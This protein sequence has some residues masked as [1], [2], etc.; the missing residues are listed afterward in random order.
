[1]T[2]TIA[3][4]PTDEFERRLGKLS[5]ETGIPKGQIIRE[6]IEEIG[7]AN[8][9]V[10]GAVVRPDTLLEEDVSASTIHEELVNGLFVPGRTNMANI[11]HFRCELVTN[12]KTWAD[13]QGKLLSIVN[14]P[15]SGRRVAP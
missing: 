6:Q 12:P 11:A 4:R 9:L 13:W 15:G 8:G 14:G 3:I 1:M 2:H 10:Q 5:R 7:P